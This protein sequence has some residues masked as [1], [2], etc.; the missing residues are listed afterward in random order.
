[1]NSCSQHKK[2]NNPFKIFKWAKDLNRH[3]SKEDKPKFEKMLNIISHLFVDACS[4]MSNS[5]G[6]QWNCSWPSSSVHGIF[7]A[8]IL[9][10][11]AISFS[12]GSSRLRDRTQVSCIAGRRFNL[13]ATREA[14]NIIYSWD[15]YRDYNCF[16]VT[17]Q[18][19][20]KWRKVKFRAL[21]VFEHKNDLNF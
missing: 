4:V 2:P 7:Q 9:E 20:G 18:I 19:G 5:L 15:I 21:D 12:R 8:R 3:F 10:W 11:V 6:P 13:W 17:I 16:G 1:M 14:P